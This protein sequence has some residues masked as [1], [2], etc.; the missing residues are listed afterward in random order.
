MFAPR[1]PRPAKGSFA[2]HRALDRGVR[3]CRAH[4]DALAIDVRRPLAPRRARRSLGPA[5]NRASRRRALGESLPRD[6]SPLSPPSTEPKDVEFPRRLGEHGAFAL[7]VVAREIPRA[8]RL[9]EEDARESSRALGEASGGASTRVDD[10]DPLRERAGTHGRAD[11]RDDAVRASAEGCR[12]SESVEERLRR[13]LRSVLRASSRVTIGA[14]KRAAFATKRVDGDVPSVPRRRERDPGHAGDDAT[15]ERALVRLAADGEAPRAERGVRPES[16]HLRRRLFRERAS[17]PS[18]VAPKSPPAERGGERANGGGCGGVTHDQSRALDELDVASPGSERSARGGES[19]APDERT[20]LGA[21]NP[22]RRRRVHPS[23]ERRREPVRRPTCHHAL[24]RLATMREVRRGV[25]PRAERLVRARSR[26]AHREQHRVI[27]RRQSVQRRPGP[28]R[29]RGVHIAPTPSQERRVRLRARHPRRPRGFA[30]TSEG[31]RRVA[32]TPPEEN[33]SREISHASSLRR[34]SAA[35]GGPRGEALTERSLRQTRAD[36]PHEMSLAL[37]AFD[38][39]RPRDER[40]VSLPLE[41]AKD[42]RGET[43]AASTFPSRQLEP[44]EEEIRHARSHPPL[45]DLGADRAHASNLA[46]FGRPPGEGA[47]YIPSTHFRRR[48]SPQQLDESVVSPRTPPD[49]R[50]ATPR[51][52]GTR[53]AIARAPLG[54][55]RQRASRATRITHLGDPRVERR[56]HA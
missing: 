38:R 16:A 49:D 1:R 30:P 23:V 44:R 7:P 28:L 56:R 26:D 32:E 43:P 35:L 14:A 52:P 31:A 27:A 10:E 18:L 9:A 55:L 4:L 24:E 45:G 25:A 50:R 37:D 8:N 20:H 33:A 17:P 15:G 5:A 19:N 46:D 11:S 29:E 6:G 47:R 40:G 48:A 2:S 12:A 51:G 42:E 3:P 54:H 39:S 36:D 34:A 53:G 22:R 41:D 13:A 21:A